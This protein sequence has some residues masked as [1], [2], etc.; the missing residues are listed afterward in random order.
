MAQNATAK[1]SMAAS[2]NDLSQKDAIVFK[3]AM[4]H[5]NSKQ[6]K[7]SMKLTESLL[8]K[9][10]K[11]GE[12]LSLKALLL[13]NMDPNREEIIEIAKQGLKN[14]IKSYLCWHVLGV[15]YKTKAQYKDAIK[16]FSMA[17]RLDPNNDRL[18]KDICCMCIEVG[19]LVSFRKYCTNLV[20]LRSKSFREWMIFAFCQH[21]CGDLELASNILRET[22]ILFKCNYGV[23]DFELSQAM[24]YTLRVLEQAGKYEECLKNIEEKGH[25]I[26][27][28]QMLLEIKGMVAI[29]TRQF[30]L[31]N[32]CY[33]H[34]LELNPDNARYVL[35]YLATYY[36]PAVSKLFTIPFSSLKNGIFPND[37]AKELQNLSLIS[38]DDILS[39]KS[40][41]L[42]SDE[43][44]DIDGTLSAGGWTFVQ[45]MKGHVFNRWVALK[46]QESLANKTLFEHCYIFRD[47]VKR[48]STIINL[49]DL[50]PPKDVASIQEATIIVSDHVQLNAPLLMYMRQGKMPKRAKYPMFLLKRRLEKCESSAIIKAL[51]EANLKGTFLYQCLAMAFSTRDNF[52]PRA[53]AILKTLADRTNAMAYFAH[54]CT[55]EMAYLLLVLLHLHDDHLSQFSLRNFNEASD[56]IK[57]H[58]ISC[59][60][61]LVHM[62]IFMARLYD[63][64]GD[65]SSALKV[66]DKTMDLA[67]TSVDLFTIRGKILKHMGNFKCSKIN[68]CMASD[69]D[70]SDRQ[71]SAKA[72]Y[73]LVR[74]NK[75]EAA[76]TKWSSFLVEDEC[77]TCEPDTRRPKEPHM[78]IPSFKFEL[79]FAR[80]YYNLYCAAIAQGHVETVVHDKTGVEWLKASLDVNASILHN[81]HEIYKDQLDFHNY[82]LNRLGHWTFYQFLRM[83]KMFCGHD[84]YIKAFKGILKGC[85]QLHYC[86]LEHKFNKPF[87]NCTFE[88]LLHF[89][90]Y[91][92]EIINIVNSQEIHDVGL[93]SQYYELAR[94]GKWDLDFKCACLVNGYQAS[95]GN[96]LHYN[97]YPMVFTF[98][99]DTLEAELTQLELETV[100]RTLEKI[101]NSKDLNVKVVN[102]H[103][104]NSSTNN[105]FTLNQAALVLLNYIRKA[106]VLCSNPLK[107]TQGL[108]RCLV[109]AKGLEDEL[110][111]VLLEARPYYT[112]CKRFTDYAKHYR[113]LVQAWFSC[114]IE[115]NKSLLNEEI[116]TFRQFWMSQYPHAFDEHQ[117]DPSPP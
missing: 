13:L 55:F 107:H 84:Y 52:I 110:V 86:K 46:K 111:K 32:S 116:K 66:I 10:P 71:T 3:N 64:L 11:H 38:N 59:S 57:Q 40:P 45:E 39:L 93:Y 41:I 72:A 43:V 109:N 112:S 63:Y 74:A 67:P 34:L 7:K 61:R 30:D 103:V 100:N 19:D 44:L 29:I 35:L 22:H 25:L 50:P 33:R 106:N 21:L 98:L 54:L 16:S 76:R 5:F 60:Y 91:C 104:I 17:V 97:V 6:Y 53:N 49:S 85:L 73:A 1:S 18:I 9:Y 89:F 78:E 28:Y 114:E 102:G 24:I 92:R 65:Y 27:D 81:L 88:Q 37:I 2:N 90:D 80:Q 70:R 26:K 15:I 14:N 56:D 77:T 96:L 4:D 75:F 58:K 48:A 82:C 115:A 113:F 23:E 42:L 117:T 87:G 51:V 8:L 69:L 101:L 20:Q 31:A 94:L 79:M 83:R 12:L 68:F 99:Y 62:R 108:V 105:T 95:D 47:Y 36:D